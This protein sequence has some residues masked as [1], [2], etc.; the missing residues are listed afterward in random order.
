MNVHHCRVM[1]NEQAFCSY[2]L[3]ELLLCS[4]VEHDGSCLHGY[5]NKPLV[6]QSIICDHFSCPEVRMYKSKC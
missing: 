5:K 1:A 6:Y 4:E 2:F 3:L